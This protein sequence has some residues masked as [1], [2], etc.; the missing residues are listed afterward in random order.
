MENKNELMQEHKNKQ[1]K[2][3]DTGDCVTLTA[4]SKGLHWGRRSKQRD[5]RGSNAK[6]QESQA[7]YASRKTSHGI[8]C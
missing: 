6:V 1:G 3:R 4:A 5:K 2:M 8:H 7:S